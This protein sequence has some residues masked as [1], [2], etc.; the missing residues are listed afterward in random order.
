[1]ATQRKRTTTVHLTRRT[2]DALQQRAR[3]A[4]KDA[5]ALADEMLAQAMQEKAQPPQHETEREMIRRIMREEGVVLR[6]ASEY[7]DLIDPDVDL[8]QAAAEL[9]AL[10]LDPPLSETIIAERHAR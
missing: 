1:M 2:F 10:R 7:Q 9:R 4:G 5:D 3:R 8:E 6:D